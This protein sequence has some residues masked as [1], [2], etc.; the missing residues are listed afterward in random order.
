MCLEEAKEY[1]HCE[2]CS[3][4]HFPEPN[5]DGIRVLGEP[6][7]VECPLCKARLVHAAAGGI[8]LLY[9]ERCR[10]VLSDMDAFVVMIQ[11]LR[12]ALERASAPPRPTVWEEL[13]REV[14][15]PNCQEP[16][17]THPYAGPGNIVIDNCPRCQL[18]WLD[19]SEL[20]RITSAP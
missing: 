17:H 11:K 6:S 4:M 12:A 5:A 7:E 16:M 9:C 2:Y 20:R 14:R 15:C 18:N 10:G 3:T 8:R 13:E 1:F 19:H